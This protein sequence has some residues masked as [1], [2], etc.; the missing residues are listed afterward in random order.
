MKQKKPQGAQGV[1]GISISFNGRQLVTRARTMHLRL[2]VLD[3]IAN[4]AA[5]IAEESATGV[6][7]EGYLQ[8]MCNGK[9]VWVKGENLK[10]IKPRK[11]VVNKLKFCDTH[12]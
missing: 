6:Y 4:R 7:G 1:L 2:G 3:E 5:D 10:A 9:V 12:G 11:K 8:A